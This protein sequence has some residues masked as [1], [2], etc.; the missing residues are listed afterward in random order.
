MILD[1]KM[2][3]G[4]ET[5]GV[6]GEIDL[7][8]QNYPTGKSLLIISSIQYS[9]IAVMVKKG[10]TPMLAGTKGASLLDKLP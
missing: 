6:E 5:V 10:W 7:Y 1:H 3:K 4:D 2:R 9:A 8:N